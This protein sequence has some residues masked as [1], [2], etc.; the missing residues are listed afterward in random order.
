AFAVYNPLN[1][2]RLRAEEALARYFPTFSESTLA[3][4]SNASPSVAN[5]M[6]PLQSLGN[7]QHVLNM[8][9]NPYAHLFATQHLKALV[10]SHFQLLSIPQKIELRT[11]ILNYLGTKGIRLELYVMTGLAELFGLVTKLGWFDA[12]EFQN[13]L[14]D[15]S[16]FLQA[17]NEHRIVGILILASLV[18]EMNRMTAVLKNITR[19]RKVGQYIY[20]SFEHTPKRIHHMFIFPFFS[21]S[22]PSF[23]TAVNFRD[24][25][26]TQIFTLCLDA[27]RELVSKQIA[28]SN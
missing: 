26:L 10:I 23:H 7:C 18:Q 11:F 13:S 3:S 8:S 6:G 5:P 4:V 1:T 20:N 25:Q 9:N 17:S 16:K 15:A 19:H 2:D 12:D 22:F 27:I 24:L 21:P 14:V 28:F